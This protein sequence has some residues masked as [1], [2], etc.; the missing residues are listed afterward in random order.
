MLRGAEPWPD[1]WHIQGSWEVLA[2]GLALE[3]LCL[4]GLARRGLVGKHRQSVSLGGDEG[5][6]WPNVKM[7]GADPSKLCS[8]TALPSLHTDMSRRQPAPSPD[9]VVFCQVSGVLAVSEIANS[10]G[11]PAKGKVAITHCARAGPS[12]TFFLFSLDSEGLAHFTLT[13]HKH[14]I[15]L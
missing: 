7:F 11:K 2:P 9:F 1:C 4:A 5:W 10:L 6:P 8:F 13:K 3:V 15:P 12:G 14:K